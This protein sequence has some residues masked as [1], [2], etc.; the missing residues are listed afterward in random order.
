MEKYFALPTTK[1]LAT[2]VKEAILWTSERKQVCPSKTVI[3]YAWNEHDEGG[4]LCP[5]IDENRKVDDSR[6]KAI[7]KVLKSMK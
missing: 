6:L 7:K 1:E 5:T 4:W 3:I 2:H